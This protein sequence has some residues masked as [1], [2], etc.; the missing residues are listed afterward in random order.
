MSDSRVTQI[1][2]LVGDARS[3]VDELDGELPQS[4]SMVQYDLRK[5]RAALN[6]ATTITNRLKGNL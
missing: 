6:S 3:I 2:T 4:F 1:E 5:L